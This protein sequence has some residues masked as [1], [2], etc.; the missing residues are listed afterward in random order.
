MGCLS[1]FFFFFFFL[2]S[3]FFALTFLH[4]VVDEFHREVI[5]VLVANH[6]TIENPMSASLIAQKYAITFQKSFKEGM[7]LLR[8]KKEKEVW[9][10]ILKDIPGISWDSTANDD[11]SHIK[12]YL[13]TSPVSLEM[14]NNRLLTILKDCGT[15]L[16]GVRAG[17][18]FN[19][20]AKRYGS[21]VPTDLAPHSHLRAAKHIAQLPGVLTTFEQSTD[22]ISIPTFS[23]VDQPVE[24]PVIESF[25]FVPGPDNDPSTFEG[26][27]GGDDCF[28]APSSPVIHGQSSSKSESS[29]LDPFFMSDTTPSGS[30]ELDD[31]KNQFAPDIKA[32]VIIAE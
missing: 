30:T 28:S 16:N 7:K 10:K 32:E 19:E 27:G 9:W 11:S 3:F 1:F 29:S 17:L 26:F 20:Y 2:H 24:V 15:T 31:M 12:F 13:T 22:G 5:S 8:D 21:L 25:D 23:F 14:V 18:I 4:V 6:A